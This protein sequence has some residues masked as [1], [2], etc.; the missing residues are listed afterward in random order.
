VVKRAIRQGRVDV[1]VSNAGYGLVGAA[2]ELSDTQV[3]GS[4]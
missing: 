1:V 4:I 2:E 3:A